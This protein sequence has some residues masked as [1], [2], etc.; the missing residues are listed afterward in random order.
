MRANSSTFAPVSTGHPKLVVLC[1]NETERQ[2]ALRSLS[3][4]QDCDVLPVPSGADGRVAEHGVRKAELE[5]VRRWF[6]RRDT[7]RGFVL[8]GFPRNVADA[9]VL[10]ELL[11]AG[12]ESFTAVL[13]GR[14]PVGLDE[15]D[16]DLRN[17]YAVQGLSVLP[18]CGT[19]TSI[20]IG[21]R[22]EIECSQP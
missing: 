6:S 10:D 18:F 8:A 13:D 7:R 20:A 5:M 14:D 4:L 9:V 19:E 11:E 12:N 21:C 3:S 22:S 17:Y 1:R 2:R 16:V 15:S